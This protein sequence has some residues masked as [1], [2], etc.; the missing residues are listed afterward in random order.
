MSNLEEE[1]FKRKAEQEIKNYE[2]IKTVFTKIY[3]IEKELLNKRKS[4][5]Q[6]IS[7]IKEEDNEVLESIY[8]NF[9]EQM[10]GL[11]KYRENLMKKIQEKLIPACKYYISNSKQAKKDIGKYKD[12]KKQ[13]EKQ[14]FELEK[15]KV[16]RNV[17]K[18]SQLNDEI[19]KSKIEIGNDLNNIQ[20]NMI[21]Y[22]KDRI[23]D[24]KYIILHF[25]HC[26]LA[27]HAK[28]LEKLSELY[29]TIKNLEPKIYLKEFADKLQFKSVNVEDYGY[30]ERE[31]TKRSINPGQSMSQSGIG[32][33]NMK[34]LKASGLGNSK[35]GMLQ[36]SQKSQYDDELDEIEEKS[37][38]QNENEI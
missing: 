15:A 19:Q 8:K 17:I 6:D 34:S 1:K 5:F 4:S 37:E 16:S 7:N 25:I 26:E 22:E 9:T 12:K 14:E 11:E 23:V 30:D 21:Q 20:K 29:K 35:R 27:Y 18:E 28:S 36:Q 38:N 10:D 31:Y 32:K 33:S 13:N 3:D 24:S 2:L